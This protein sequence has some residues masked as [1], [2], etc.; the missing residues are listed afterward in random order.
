VADEQDRDRKREDTRT[1]SRA[2]RDGTDLKSQTAYVLKEQRDAEQDGAREI[3]GGRQPVLPA[4]ATV[5]RRHDPSPVERSAPNR[6]R[7]RG[8]A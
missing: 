5:V 4:P 2:H 1:G 6:V 7:D 3:S 8:P